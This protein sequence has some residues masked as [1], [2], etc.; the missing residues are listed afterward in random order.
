MKHTLTIVSNKLREKIII[1]GIEHLKEMQPESLGKLVD[2]LAKENNEVETIGNEFLPIRNVF[3]NQFVYDVIKKKTHIASYIG[4]GSE[5]PV[6][7]R[8]AVAT[9]HG[10]LAKLGI[11]HIVTEEE[12]LSLHHAR[13][14]AENRAMIDQLVAKGVDL[15]NAI[16][17][18]IEISRLKALFLGEFSYNDGQVNIGVDYGVENRVELTGAEA[19]SDASSTPLSDLIKWND[20][21]SARNGQTADVIF[22][23]RESR[24]LLQT[25]PEIIAEAR[26]DTP[27]ARVSVAELTEVLSGYGLPPIRIVERRSVT[28]H[29]MVTGEEVINEY[30]PKYRIVFASQGT[31]EYLMGITVENNF[32]P[33]VTLTAKDK[34]E[35]IQSIMRS[36]AAGFPVIEDP[37]LLFYADVAEVTP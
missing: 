34:D 29:D 27:T 20:E 15:V 23:S 19:W 8:D 6:M 2:A 13:S 26:G 25:N 30:M 35:P 16:Y 10:E 1:A 12:L 5:P 17:L 33:G 14:N 32:Q 9:R 18:Q 3:S 21:Y 28:T 11:K 36:V 24:A 37:E 7:D 22:M 4:F 31:G